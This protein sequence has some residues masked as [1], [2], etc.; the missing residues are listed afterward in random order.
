MGMVLWATGARAV[1]VSAKMAN[2]GLEVDLVDAISSRSTTARS[3]RWRPPGSIKPGQGEQ[4]ELRYYG[5]AG[6]VLQQPLTGS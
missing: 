4:L 5:N 2:A 3:G 6:Y 1:E